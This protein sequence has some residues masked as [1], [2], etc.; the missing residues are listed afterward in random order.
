MSNS[1][2]VTLLLTC[3]TGALS[4]H[5]AAS[6]RKSKFINYT[7]IGVSATSV[8]ADTASYFNHVL[9]VPHGSD[10]SYIDTVHSLCTAYSVDCILPGA[11][12]E[13]LAFSTTLSLFHDI[14]IYPLIP[15]KRCLELITNKAS[16]YRLLSQNSLPS[17][18]FAC[19]SNPRDLMHAVS[20]YLNI[21]QS[22][23]VKPACSRG[24]RHVYYVNN[25]VSNLQDKLRNQRQTVFTLSE[26]SSLDISN[27]FDLYD[28]L[29]VMQLMDAPSYDV[30][31]LNTRIF[32]EPIVV[33]RE[34]IN[35]EGI[36]F[37]GNIVDFR[38]ELID[39]SKKIGELLF[40]DSLVDIDI[41]TG[42]NGTPLL[43]ECNP[44]PSGSIAASLSI[45]YPLID[46]LVAQTLNFDIDFILPLHPPRVAVNE[47]D[48]AIL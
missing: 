33:P 6:L 22:V 40:L 16:T 13:V 48:L 31:F 24:G 1:P 38:P 26:F 30:D 23:V 27:L 44:R 43:L 8:D 18:D 39:Y 10:P 29:V 14:D 5:V 3:I 34:R 12:E 11:D 28:E 46:I 37:Q 7:I 17:P 47:S 42:A 15:G 32:P 20:N 4:R 19:A 41:M 21:H 25:S 45:G 2:S 36:P 9:K 35:K